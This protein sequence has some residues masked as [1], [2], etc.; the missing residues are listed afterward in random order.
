MNLYMN[1]LS[2]L[3]QAGLWVKLQEKFCSLLTF[4]QPKLSLVKI[5]FLPVEV[6][7][8]GFT[9]QMFILFRSSKKPKFPLCSAQINNDPIFKFHSISMLNAESILSKCHAAVWSLAIPVVSCLPVFC[10]LL[11]I[12]QVDTAI[13]DTSCWI[14][15][16]STGFVPRRWK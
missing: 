14:F 16:K 2:I 10:V 6:Q 8:K 11:L 7:W 15:Y 1:N 5:L 4:P 9:I 3:F 12:L 13:S